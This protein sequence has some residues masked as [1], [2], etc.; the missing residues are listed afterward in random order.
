MKSGP[1]I[2]I[3][4]VCFAHESQE[5]G[6]HGAG[7]RGAMSG[8]QAAMLVPLFTLQGSLALANVL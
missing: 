8:T 7:A 4:C 1:H 3:L 5:S 6:R 2:P